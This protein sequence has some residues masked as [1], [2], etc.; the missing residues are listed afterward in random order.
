M[1]TTSV[2]KVK[3]VREV[4]RCVRTLLKTKG[5]DLRASQIEEMI[6]AQDDLDNPI[7][8]CARLETELATN[9]VQNTEKMVSPLRGEIERFLIANPDFQTEY[10]T[11]HKSVVSNYSRGRLTKQEQ[12]RLRTELLNKVANALGNAS[13]ADMDDGDEEQEHT[14]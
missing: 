13:P 5:H 8:I 7:A 4:A 1:T 9:P 12:D 14:F 11:L 10:P 6:N 3:Q 2:E